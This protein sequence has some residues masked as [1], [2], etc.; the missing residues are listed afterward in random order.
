MQSGVLLLAVLTTLGSTVERATIKVL[1]AHASVQ[2]GGIKTDKSSYTQGET[3][4]ISGATPGQTL[5][6]QKVGSPDRHSVVVDSK[7]NASFT[8]SDTGT[9]M[10]SDMNFPKAKWTTI[11]VVNPMP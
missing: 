10:I 8:P 4:K 3:V 5:Y 1:P 9:W 7:G 11:T 2:K 6:Y